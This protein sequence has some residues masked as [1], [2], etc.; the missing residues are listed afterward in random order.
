LAQQLLGLFSFTSG[1]FECFG[2]SLAPAE[3]WCDRPDGIASSYGKKPA[4]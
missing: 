1:Q 2:E 3:E 4:S